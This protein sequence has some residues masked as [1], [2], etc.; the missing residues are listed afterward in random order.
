M[1]PGD[2]ADELRQLN[3]NSNKFN[4]IKLD[5]DVRD[6][7]VSALNARHAARRD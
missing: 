4:A 7:L 3:F 2:I 6:F 1:T 5:A